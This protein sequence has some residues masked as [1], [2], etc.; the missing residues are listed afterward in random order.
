MLSKRNAS[1]RV[2]ASDSESVKEQ[3]AKKKV[4]TS[5][6]NA[7]V[8]SVR[9]MDVCRITGGTGETPE[10]HFLDL[11][12]DAL[13]HML[14]FL[15]VEDI[16]RASATCRTLR[17]ASQSNSLW[18]YLCRP[19][20]EAV[21][22]RSWLP[23][24]NS[25]KALYRLL[26][27][28]SYI[29]GPWSADELAPRGGLLYVTWVRITFPLLLTSRRDYRSL[30]LPSSCSSR[31]SCFRV[32]CLCPPIA[33]SPPTPHLTASAVCPSSPATPRRTAPLVSPWG[34]PTLER[35]CGMMR[36]RR[37]ST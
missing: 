32:T 1:S 17:S 14:S 33:S 12:P 28:F 16:L 5:K 9:S 34:R 2:S 35:W 27:E 11:P 26:K 4:C 24:F 3:I 19:W 21:P 6:R 13:T 36:V 23:S 8:I 25:G 22:Y 37:G 7:T 18:L 15:S 20:G 30:M 29:V 10:L 31:S